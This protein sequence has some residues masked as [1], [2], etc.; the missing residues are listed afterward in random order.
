MDREER[1]LD[2]GSGLGFKQVALIMGLIFAVTLAVVVG[3]QMSAEAMAVVVGVVCGVAAAIPTSVLLVVVMTRGERQRLHR[4]DQRQARPGQYPPVVVI[5]GGASQALPPGMQ[6]GYWP[7][8]MP[9]PGAE[10][11]FQVVGGDELVEANW[12]Q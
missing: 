8:A 4:E 7:G 10:R 11:R 12:Y 6:T 5:Q 3:K 9:G 1:G 2:I